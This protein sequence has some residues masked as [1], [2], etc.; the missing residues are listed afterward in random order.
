ME[1]TASDS[2][3]DSLARISC[4]FMGVAFGNAPDPESIKDIVDKVLIEDRADRWNSV[5][6]NPSAFSSM[7][8]RKEVYKRLEQEWADVEP[9]KEPVEL[10][11]RFAAGTSTHDSYQNFLLGRSGVLWGDWRCNC[12]GAYVVYQTRPEPCPNTVHVQDAKTGRTRTYKCADRVRKGQEWSYAEIKVRSIS[13]DQNYQVRGRA[14]GVIIQED[15]TWYGL[16]MKSLPPEVFEGVYRVKGKDENGEFNNTYV[17]KP[18]GMR[19]PMPS[20]AFQGSQCTAMLYMD[21]LIGRAPLD[22]E[23]CRGTIILY[24]NRDTFEE[25]EFILPLNLGILDYTSEV[26]ESVRMLVKSGTAELAP[27]KCSN[28]SSEAAKRCKWRDEC[29][30]KKVRKKKVTKKKATKKTDE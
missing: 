17:L 12:C 19:L 29:F 25:K 14:D 4:Q 23:L 13:E 8:I 7:C 22:P 5:A 27:K 30:P 28:R 20:H 16:E 3:V 26:I 10:Y 2:W 21:C 6:F 1:K 24:I 11:R 18:G 15:L 9:A